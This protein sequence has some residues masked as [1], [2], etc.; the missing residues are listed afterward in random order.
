MCF[1]YIRAFLDTQSV[2]KIP[3]VGRMTEATLRAFDINNISDIRKH[4][5]IIYKVFTPATINFLFA[6]SVGESGS[7]HEE[8][9]VAANRKSISCDRTFS[10]ITSYS[11]VLKKLLYISENIAEQLKGRL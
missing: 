8:S 7:E 5:D 9:L 11:E 6:S 4:A 3:G 2:R 10:P 1:H